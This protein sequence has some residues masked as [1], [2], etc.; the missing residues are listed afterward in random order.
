M[1]YAKFM[2]MGIVLAVLSP[3]VA[4]GADGNG[5]R[6]PAQPPK[7]GQKAD[8]RQDEDDAGIARAA[9]AS[10]WAMPTRRSGGR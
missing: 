6:A 4:R 5:P 2:L 3:D 9:P 8:A 7:G 10:R 1:Q